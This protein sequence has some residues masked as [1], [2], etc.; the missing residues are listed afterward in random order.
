MRWKLK[1][2]LQNSIARLPEPWSQ[3]CYYAVQCAAGSFRHPT[4]SVYSQ[5][6]NRLRFYIERH[7]GRIDGATFLEVGTGRNLTLPVLLWLMGA[8]R[9]YTVDLHRYLRMPIVRLD[10]QALAASTVVPGC[11]LDR[12]DKLRE[13][14]STQW[15]LSALMDL[16]AIDYSAP[17]DA[18]RLKLPDASID[19]HVSRT[20]FE[21]IPAKD[22]ERIL[23][24]SGRLLRPDGLAIHLV[25]YSDHFSH[26]DAAIS[27]INFLQYDDQDWARL[28]GNSF[29]YMNRLRAD[30]Y[31]S[32]YATAGQAIVSIESS[33]A[34]A[35]LAQLDDPSFRLAERFGGKDRDTL[36][37]T[38]SWIISRPLGR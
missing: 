20:V 9:V 37:T 32:I 8:E 25:D 38:S 21:H 4:V 23:I 10:L 34:P 5:A 26:S 1:A 19:Y 33:Q 36:I 31:P 15:Q 24:E 2:L 12:L 13:F 22:L 11:Q 17:A 7:G 3:A 14:L 6:A 16:C 27:A 35:L 28:A 18:A 29:M 30:D